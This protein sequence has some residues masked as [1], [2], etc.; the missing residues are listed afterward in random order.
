MAKDKKDVVIIG[1]GPAGYVAA[2]RSA[3]AGA[4]TVLIER[5]KVGGTCLNVG[6]ISTKVLA[7]TAEIFTQAGKLEAYGIKVSKPGLDYDTVQKRKD[8]VVETLTGGVGV[9]L[10]NYGVEVIKGDATFKTPKQI[11][12]SSSKKRLLDPDKVIIAAGA[13]PL[14]LPALPFDGINILNSTDLLNLKQLPETLLVVGGGVVGVEFA[15]I[16]NQ[17]GVKVCLVEMLPHLLPNLDVEI[18]EALRAELQRQTIEV[19]TG[20]KVDQVKISGGKVQVTLSGSDRQDELT[21]EK[22]L[23]AAGRVPQLESLNLKAAGITVEKGAVKVNEKMETSVSGIYAAGD[24]CGGYQLASVAYHEGAIAA[25]NANGSSLESDFK[26]MPYCIFT[27]PEVAGVGLTEEQAKKKF[28]ELIVKRFPFSANG[29]ALAAGTQNGYIKMIAEPVHHE[30]LGFFIIG[31]SA[32]ELIHQAAQV[33]KM[34][35]VVDD[36]AA[37]VYGHPTLSE[38][39]GEVALMGVNKPLHMV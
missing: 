39:V 24:V 5:D 15:S 26:E 30:I 1:G 29:K 13:R 32:T 37:M 33:M 12:V 20:T 23:V 18:S 35:G 8:E 34:E 28:Q 2:I 31:P 27:N 25:A 19:R 36:L 4:G 11:E 7:K 9:L 22:V 14:E 3:Q 10:E 38:A 21:V 6:C 17:F 16:M